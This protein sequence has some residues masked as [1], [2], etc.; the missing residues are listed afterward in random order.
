MTL[1]FLLSEDT[2][3]GIRF[4]KDFFQCAEGDMIGIAVHDDRFGSGRTVECDVGDRE[5]ED[6]T[7]VQREFGKILRDHRDHA[8]IMRTRAD[9]AE[10]HLIAFDEH[11]HAEN[12][13]SADGIRDFFRDILRF[14]FGGIR[15]CLR[16]PGFLIIAVHLMVSDRFQE[17]SS[18]CV[19]DSQKSDFIIEIDETFDDDFTGSGASAFLSDFPGCFDAR[20]RKTRGQSPSQIRASGPATTS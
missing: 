4:G 20:I 2:H 16:L 18:S 12:T 17:E 3:G 9:L 1:E 10:D 15:H 19:T 11:F 6:R 5:T 8:R 7:G 13:A 14:G